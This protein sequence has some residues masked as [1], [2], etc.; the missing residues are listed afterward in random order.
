MRRN[1]FFGVADI[2]GVRTQIGVRSTFQA[3]AV[4]KSGQAFGIEN[5]CSLKRRL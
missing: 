2:S 3:T 4:C 5:I 1:V